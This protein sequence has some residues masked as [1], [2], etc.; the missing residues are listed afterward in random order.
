MPRFVYI[1]T[2]YF[3]VFYTLIPSFSLEVEIYTDKQVYAPNEIV[4]VFITTKE[5]EDTP[6][7]VSLVNVTVESPYGIIETKDQSTRYVGCVIK[8]FR[9]G[10]KGLCTITAD[11]KKISVSRN[12]AISQRD[13]FFDDLKKLR[14][15]VEIIIF[16]K[17]KCAECPVANKI[18]ENAKIINSEKISVRGFDIDKSKEAVKLGIYASP[19][20]VINNE[21]KIVG[22]HG[23]EEF[24]EDL[25][26]EILEEGGI[27]EGKKPIFLLTIPLA[28][29]GFIFLLL[30][31][32]SLLNKKE[33]N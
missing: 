10:R 8:T 4:T 1:F 32:K 5:P 29:A 15:P 17:E 30:F 21:K 20:V 11:F 25:R 6:V 19:T 12:I 16:S 28:I 24:R 31:L 33:A 18:V 26:R 9:P 3:I 27:E 13:T 22:W 2:L 23:Y 7:Y 14:N